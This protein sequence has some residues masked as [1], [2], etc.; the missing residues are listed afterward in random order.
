[1]TYL[2]LGIGCFVGG[3][4]ICRLYYAK[5]IEIGKSVIHYAEDDYQKARNF[6][7]NLPA[8]LGL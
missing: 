7:M 8:K 3:I 6:L 1:M 5:A 4:I 2:F